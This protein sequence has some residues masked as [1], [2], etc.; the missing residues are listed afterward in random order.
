MS[1]INKIEK[2]QWENIKITKQTIQEPV[3]KNIFIIEY[4]LLS[5]KMNIVKKILKIDKN[6]VVKLSPS[7]LVTICQSY[8]FT[9]IIDLLSMLDTNML[10]KILL[11]TEY[12]WFV[13]YFFKKASN[14]MIKKLLKFKKHI[15]FSSMYNEHSILRV[16]LTDNYMNP[17]MDLLIEILKLSKNLIT[18]NKNQKNIITQCCLKDYNKDVL[19]NIIDLYPDILDDYDENMVTPLIASIAIGNDLLTNYILKK[20]NDINYFGTTS[21]LLAAIHVKN[22][23]IIS[24]ILAFSDIDVNNYNLQKWLPAH[25]IFIKDSQIS[26]ENKRLILEKTLNIN[27]QNLHGNT[28]LHLMCLDD[29]LDLYKDIMSNK[30]ID[31]FVQNVINKT[32][33]HYCKNIPLLLDIASESFI[34]NL[35][36]TQYKNK[37]LKKIP[38]KDENKMIIETK[39]CLDK[40]IKKVLNNT[41]EFSTDENINFV[42]EDYVDYSLFTATD[43]DSLLYILYFIETYGVKIPINN[44]EKKY[45]LLK[46]SNK[47]EIER[48]FDLYLRSYEENEN[49]QNFNILWHDINNYCYSALLNETIKNSVKK[50]IMFIYV[51]IID[52]EFDHANG[53]IIDHDLKKIIHFEP[54]GVLNSKKINDFNNMFTKFFNKCLPKYTYFM[55][56][57]YMS[58]NSFQHLSNETNKY[59][60]KIGDIGGF[61]LAWTLWFLELY[62]NNN[63]KDLKHL[64][65]NAIEKIINTKFQFSDYIRAYAHKLTNYKNNVLN[66]INYPASKLFNIH[67]NQQQIDYIFNSVNNMIN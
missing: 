9:L 47:P 4:A 16:Y 17:D 31:L 59:N 62:I 33:I 29:N 39:K 58:V 14:E 55:P 57:N 36:K 2:N 27:T 40:K 53:I 19:N 5:G 26:L 54:Y 12:D 66:K 8:N 28:V 35:H 18:K 52:V 49:L 24:K 13:L 50:G 20:T 6:N 48:V 10:K 67:K 1:S 21:A 63:D 37:N 7:V 34:H 41:Y 44:T 30:I 32:P 56:K 23:K 64:V 3:Y 45:K 15:S 46:K 22:D 43:Y 65:Q 60:I 61:C 42:M 11:P 25:L 51:T 38:K